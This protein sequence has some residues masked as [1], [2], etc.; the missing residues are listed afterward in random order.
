MVKIEDDQAAIFQPKTG[1]KVEKE[2][3]KGDALTLLGSITSAASAKKRKAKKGP[4]GVD[5]ERKKA[6]LYQ[7]KVCLHLH[8]G[9]L[10][11]KLWLLY[12]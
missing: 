3:D 5:D 12:V 6:K 9:Q 7:E 2:E 8:K 10:K 11:N 4:D 1:I